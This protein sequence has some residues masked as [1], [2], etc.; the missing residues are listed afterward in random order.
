MHSIVSQGSH[1]S[2]EGLLTVC[3]ASCQTVKSKRTD[4]GIAAMTPSGAHVSR[5]LGRWRDI[6]AEFRTSGCPSSP[7]YLGHP[8]VFK[9]ACLLSTTFSMRATILRS[10]QGPGNTSVCWSQPFPAVG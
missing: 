5:S 4:D 2:I 3:Q 7:T 8:S 10:M 1:S 6:S 9:D